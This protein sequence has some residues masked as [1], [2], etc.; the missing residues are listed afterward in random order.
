MTDLDEVLK[1]AEIIKWLIKYWFPSALIMSLFWGIRA[2]F[3][4]L[5]KQLKSETDKIAMYP[6]TS[7]VLVHVVYQFLFHFI[8]SFAGWFCF[9]VLLLKANASLLSFTGSDFILFLISLLGLTGHI[10]QTLYG[11]VVSIGKF[12]ETGMEWLKKITKIH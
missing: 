3:F 11:L 10:P 12:E 6:K 2:I 8:G 5:I 1:T 7:F 4:V 9:Y